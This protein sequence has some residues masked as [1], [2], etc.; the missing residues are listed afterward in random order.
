MTLALLM[1]SEKNDALLIAFGA[2]AVILLLGPYF[3]IHILSSS[4]QPR[5]PIEVRGRSVKPKS[6]PTATSNK[7]KDPPQLRK[8]HESDLTEI[9]RLLGE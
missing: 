7:R 9:E 5:A 3:G 6:R 4:P 2:I 1:N 8:R